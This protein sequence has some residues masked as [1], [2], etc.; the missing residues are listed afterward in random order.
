MFQHIFLPFA[1]SNGRVVKPVWFISQIEN[2]AAVKW[3][4]SSECQKSY[5]NS[6]G[7]NGVWKKWQELQILNKRRLTWCL[8]SLSLSLSYTHT[9]TLS[10]LPFKQYLGQCGL[11]AWFCCVAGQSEHGSNWRN[12]MNGCSLSRS[13]RPPLYFIDVSIPLSWLPSEFVHLTVWADRCT[14]TLGA[15]RGF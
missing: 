1:V 7:S 10:Q 4:N 13:K 11:L 6:T 8:F 15:K 12:L 2:N 3:I 9:H 5:K 14:W